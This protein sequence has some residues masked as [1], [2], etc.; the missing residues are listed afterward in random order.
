[1]LIEPAVYLDGPEEIKTEPEAFPSPVVWPVLRYMAPLPSVPEAVLR[2]MTPLPV[3]PEAVARVIA[4]PLSVPVP[5]VMVT[6][7]PDAIAEAGV[8]L[9]EADVSPAEL[10]TRPPAPA[11]PAPTD[12]VIAPPAPDVPV[13]DDR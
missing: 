4:P 5:V 13:P 2:V 10:D 12:S 9:G 3:E 1:M 7:P 11:L 6:V 8:L